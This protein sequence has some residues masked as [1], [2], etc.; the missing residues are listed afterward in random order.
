MTYEI[1]D[2][3][4]HGHQVFTGNV[5]ETFRRLPLP[6]RMREAAKVLRQ[7]DV[8][9]GGHV[10]DREYAWEPRELEALA[11]RFEAED[12]TKAEQEAEHVHRVD[13]LSEFL[14]T[15]MGA[16]VTELGAVMLA[17]DLDAAGWRKGGSDE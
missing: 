14:R 6:I 4:G 12:R 11:D 9:R 13:E 2:T 7:A 3:M 15:T 8:R 5:Q 16:A 10:H 1:L 17:R